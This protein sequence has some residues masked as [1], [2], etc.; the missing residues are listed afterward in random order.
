MEVI[1]SDISGIDEDP[2]TEILDDDDICDNDAL[3]GLC[4]TF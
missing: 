4:E 2:F 1:D 3:D